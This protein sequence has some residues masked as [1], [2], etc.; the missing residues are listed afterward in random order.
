MAKRKK[1]KDEFKSLG[2]VKISDVDD[3]SILDFAE[4]IINMANDEEYET[5]ASLTGN[6]LDNMSLLDIEGVDGES[7]EIIPQPNLDNYFSS[8]F[9]GKRKVFEQIDT[10]A[11]KKAAGKNN[12]VVTYTTSNDNAFFDNDKFE[13]YVNALVEK[14]VKELLPKLIAKHG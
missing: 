14:K 13:R 11:D 10:L 5:V 4:T 6:D 2:S 8:L 12:T 1:N 3:L 9:G 7:K